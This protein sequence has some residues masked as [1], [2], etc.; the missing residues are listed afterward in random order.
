MKDEIPQSQS[1]ADIKGE[2]SGIPV[3]LGC[4]SILFFTVICTAALLLVVKLV[5]NGEIKLNRGDLEGYRIWVVRGEG[6]PGFGFSS[7]KELKSDGDPGATCI[8]TRARFLVFQSESEIAPSTYCECY[9]LDK[10]RWNYIGQC[11]P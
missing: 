9:E 3:R 4:I 2:R 6:F 11:S 5:V 10:G 7:S 8:E 1:D